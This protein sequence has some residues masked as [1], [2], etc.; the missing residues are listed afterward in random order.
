MLLY[1]MLQLKSACRLQHGDSVYDAGEGRMP[2]QVNW[3]LC[4]A[5]AACM[6]HLP[7]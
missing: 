2:V 6:D 7:F 3:K 4:V 1:L 5:V